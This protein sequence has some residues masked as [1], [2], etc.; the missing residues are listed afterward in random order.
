MTNATKSSFATILISGLLLG[1]AFPLGA[2][3]LA[4]PNDVIARVGDQSITFSQI[5]LMINSSDMIGMGSPPPGNPARNQVRLILLDKMISA[6]LLHLDALKKGAES[7][8][9]YQRDVQRYS[10][11]ILASLYREKHGLGDITVTDDEVRNYYKKNIVKGTPLTP[12]VR[13]GIEATI[14]KER[15][16]TRKAAFQKELRKG[17]EIVVDSTKLEPDGDAARTSGEVVARINQETITWGELRNELTDPQKSSS[18]EARTEVLNVMIDE[19]I[20][21]DKAKAAR[22][23]RNPIFLSRINEFKKV[24]LVSLYKTKLFGEMEPTD[25]EI[26][27]YFEKNK[28]K[29]QTLESRKI[30]MVVLK[31][32]VEADDVKKKIKSGELTIFQAASQYSIDPNAKTTLG[33]LGWV[34]KGT[35][36]PELDRLAFSLKPDD[37][38]GPVET[39]AGW[40]L[41]KVLEVRETKYQDIEDKDTRQRA[42]DMLLGEKV[43]E[44]I[45]NLRKNVFPVEVYAD[46]FQRIVQKEQE[47]IEAKRKKSEKTSSPAQES[48][49]KSGAKL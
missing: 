21:V 41:V 1:V 17:N 30:Q 36:F 26:R 22:L 49:A 25:R 9:V 23:D 3:A 13:M 33:E 47:K 48:T 18:V 39:P 4:P 24:H 34:A 28:E 16:K 12:E 19:H 10:R 11:A 7:N 32:K 29:I 2:V 45:V 38:G 40:H 6:D 31:T 27:E 46:V 20:I 14:R 43:N 8:P 42:R 5:E 35:G 44:Y 37:L 15:F